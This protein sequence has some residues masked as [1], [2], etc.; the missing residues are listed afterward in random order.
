MYA[1]A[2]VFYGLPL[3]S[4]DTEIAKSPLLEENIEDESAGFNRL[5]SGGSNCEPT[6]FGIELS[7]F[8]EGCHH[9]ELSDLKLEPTKAQYDEFTKL[10]N[11]LEPEL[12]E[13]LKVY[14]EPRVFIL[15]ST[16]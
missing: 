2:T 14:G 9:V 15:W 7:E 8:D 1:I 16:S 13:E 12:Q 3:N 11:A 4:N 6:A 5:Y 10:Y